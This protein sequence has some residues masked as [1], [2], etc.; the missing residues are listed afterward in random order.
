MKTTFKFFILGLVMVMALC[1]ANPASAE[2]AFDSGTGALSAAARLNFEIVI[3]RFVY[4]R[5]GQAGIGIDTVQF[6]PTAEQVAEGTAG[7]VATSGSGDVSVS[8]VSNAGG[9]TITPTNNGSGNGLSDGGA[10]ANYI[11]YG[12]IDTSSNAGTLSAPALTNAGGTA[13]SITP[14]INA[15][16]TNISATWTYTYNN[17][18]NPPA[19]GNY[20]GQVTYT[21]ATP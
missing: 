14:N 2:T 20:T 4:F 15:N 21:A 16:V 3:P 18:T 9:V 10:I 1:Y 12:Q 19:A 8:L 11:S 13:V 7:I 5:V 17:P 6:D